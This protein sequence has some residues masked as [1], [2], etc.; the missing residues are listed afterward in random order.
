MDLQVIKTIMLR[1]DASRISEDGTDGL[2]Q[3]LIPEGE[4]IASQGTPL[5]Y[6]AWCRFLKVYRFYRLL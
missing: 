3:A 6:Q 1:L 5:K 2:L 4:S